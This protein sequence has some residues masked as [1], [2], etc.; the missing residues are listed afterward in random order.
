MDNTILLST[1]Y[2]CTHHP[3]EGNCFYYFIMSHEQ[4]HVSAAVC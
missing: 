1:N 2:F 4:L 3:Q